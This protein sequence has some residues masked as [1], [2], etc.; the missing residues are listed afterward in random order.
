MTV[1]TVLWIYHRIKYSSSGYEKFEYY[2][3]GELSDFL[4][5]VILIFEI[6][7]ALVAMVAIVYFGGLTIDRYFL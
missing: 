7:L 1:L 6:L 2:L 4:A 3:F 5:N